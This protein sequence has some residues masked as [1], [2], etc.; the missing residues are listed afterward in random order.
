MQIERGR[1]SEYLCRLTK[2]RYMSRIFVPTS[3]VA[4]WKALLADPEKQFVR[5]Y[6]AWA[7]AHSWEAQGLPIE[8]SSESKF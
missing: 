3:G 7:T 1:S 4:S 5:E 8:L 6:S 2:G